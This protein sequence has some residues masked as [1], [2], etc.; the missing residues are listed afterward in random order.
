MIDGRGV[1][2]P[3]YAARKALA[4]VASGDVEGYR[5]WLRVLQAVDTLLEKDKA[6]GV[7]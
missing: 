2:A 1:D 4:L 5:T 6:S 7:A 3:T